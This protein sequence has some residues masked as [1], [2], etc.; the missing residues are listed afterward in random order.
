LK[1]LAGFWPLLIIGLYF[2]LGLWAGFTFAPQ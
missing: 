2:L 1:E